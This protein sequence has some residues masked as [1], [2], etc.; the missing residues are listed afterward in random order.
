MGL[1]RVVKSW[2]EATERACTHLPKTLSPNRESKGHLLRYLGLGFQQ[3][4]FEGNPVQPI[5]GFKDSLLPSVFPW[6]L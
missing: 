6:D 4:N 2:T 3:R 5:V 1:E